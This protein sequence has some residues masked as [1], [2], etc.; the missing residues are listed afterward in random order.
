[1]VTAYPLESHLS[2]L[3]SNLHALAKDLV[4]DQFIRSQ[5]LILSR[6]NIHAH[7]PA[8]LALCDIFVGSSF[9]SILLLDLSSELI[10]GVSGSAGCNDPGI[11][12]VFFGLGGADDWFLCSGGLGLLGWASVGS[13][14]RVV[15]GRGIG[16]SGGGGVRRGREL[17]ALS[18]VGD[19]LVGSRVGLEMS[20]DG[21]KGC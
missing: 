20:D 1:M 2:L 6:I 18:G 13:V 5:A 19:C 15:G 17:F 4:L 14:V 10:G 12:D 7:R 3:P 16:E 8:I 11:V 21:R 9:V